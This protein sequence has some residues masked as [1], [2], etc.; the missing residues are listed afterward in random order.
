LEDIALWAALAIATAM[1]GTTVLDPKSMVTH[2]V[3]TIGFFMLGLTLLPRAVK[4]FN[5]SRYNILARNVPV[6][7]VV[8]VLLGYCAI[9][10]MLNVSLVFAAF[11]A[12]FAVVHKK[13]KLFAEPLEMVKSFSFA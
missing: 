7:Y 13:S 11:L 1:A 10:G 3:V 12:G 9:A 8:A 4:R 2:L 6:A 5:K